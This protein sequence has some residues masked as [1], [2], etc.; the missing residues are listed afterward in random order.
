M[1]REGAWA[2]LT[3]KVTLMAAFREKTAWIFLIK[4]FIKFS[5]NYSK[6]IKDA[7]IENDTFFF[8]GKV[9]EK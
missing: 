6:S 4:I 7:I 2:E 1:C 9:L 3:A 8:Y 5:K